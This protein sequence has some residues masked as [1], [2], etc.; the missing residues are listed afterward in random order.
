MSPT[1]LYLDLLKRCL[2]RE[3]FIEEE[4]HEPTFA[5]WRAHMWRPVK[6]ALERHGLHLV[7]RGGDREKRVQG[8]DWPPYAETMIGLRRLDN[9]QY[10]TETAIEDDVPGDFVE[11]GVWRGGASIFMRAVLAAHG[12]RK[13]TVWLADSFRGVPRPDPAT[14]PADERVDLFKRRELAVS[15]SEVRANFRRYGLLDSQVQFLEGWFKDTLPRAPIE[16]I[17]VLR[18]DGDLYESTMDALNALFP[19]V[20]SGGFVIV[21]DYGDLPGCAQ[22]VHDYRTRLGIVD[23]IHKIDQAGV[24]WR[25]G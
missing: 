3:L 17:A 21:D 23:D 18:L 1:R 22:A 13:R 9:L 8:R 11:T 25:R 4:V 19:K 6:R 24:F 7:R 16:R 14:Y 5:D 2:S 15:L 20:S 12:D 10:C